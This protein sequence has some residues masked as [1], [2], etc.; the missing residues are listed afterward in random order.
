M[1]RILVKVGNE[2]LHEIT[3]SNLGRQG[4]RSVVHAGGI[5]ATSTD[6]SRIPRPRLPSDK[7][8]LD[9][10][11]TVMKPADEGGFSMPPSLAGDAS[12]AADALRSGANNVAAEIDRRA[13]TGAAAEIDRARSTGNEL[14]SRAGNTLRNAA[15]SAFG[16]DRNTTAAQAAAQAQREAQLAAQRRANANSTNSNAVQPPS[17]TGNDP[18]GVYARSRQGVPSTDPTNQRDRDWYDPSGRRS[19]PTTDPIA[20]VSQPGFVGPPDL[21]ASAGQIGTS[22][23]NASV[24]VDPRAAADNRTNSTG[25]GTTPNFG[26]LPT[27]LRVPNPDPRYASTQKD[28]RY[29]RQEPTYGTSFANQQAD[30][31]RDVDPRLTEAQVAT[32]PPGA[33]SINVYG[34]PIDREGNVLDRW[35]YPVTRPAAAAANSTANAADPRLNPASPYEYSRTAT[36]TAMPSGAG[37][38]QRPSTDLYS[39]KGYPNSYPPQQPATAP[40]PNPNLQYT[41]NQTT[42]PTASVYP[43]V[44]VNPQPSQVLV[45]RVQPPTRDPAESNRSALSPSDRSRESIASS[46]R[47]GVVT[48]RL[49]EKHPL[50]NILLLVSAVANFY[51]FWWLKNLR[52]RFRDLVAAKRVTSTPSSPV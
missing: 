6:Q 32:L 40:V 37:A 26:R 31:R 28:P 43:P 2:T 10:I 17:F 41:S 52:Y 25:L 18:T 39:T 51:L 50:F 23:R 44:Q 38:N 8:D 11:E 34:E 35:G 20:K 24:F 47:S 19:T 13:R 49:A 22:G 42:A 4:D 33:W 30:Q 21:R 9:G 48:N 3:P 36:N 29:D 14:L 15:E 1:S 27:D 45:T 7:R 5:Q 46:N 16:L 12:R